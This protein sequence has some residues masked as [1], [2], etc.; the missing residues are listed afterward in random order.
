MHG[1]TELCIFKENLTSEIYVNIIDQYLIP[2]ASKLFGT[3]KF[4]ILHDH[5]PR[6]ESKKVINHCIRNGIR[7]IEEWPANSPDLNPI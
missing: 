4:L 6:H 7:F 1:K 5:D 3:Q 2:G